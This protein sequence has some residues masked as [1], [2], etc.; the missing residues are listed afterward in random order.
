TVQQPHVGEDW[1]ASALAHRI[2][3][4]LARPDALSGLALEGLALELC[5]V[6]GRA[7]APEPATWVDDAV[8]FLR[9]RFRDPPTAQELA[10]QLGVH[11]GH[12]ARCFRARTGESIGSYVRGVRLEWAADRLI[13]TNVPLARVACEAGFAD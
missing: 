7:R 3:R 9:Q 4:E 13:R 5:A 2:R 12:L 6:V 8:E 1:G 11:P 10:A